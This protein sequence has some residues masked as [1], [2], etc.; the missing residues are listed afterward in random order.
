MGKSPK[1]IQP[2]QL[3]Q[4]AMHTMGQHHIDQLLVINQ[5]NQPIGLI[6]IQDIMAISS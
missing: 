6:D 1:V 5:T 4:E 3:V 2:H